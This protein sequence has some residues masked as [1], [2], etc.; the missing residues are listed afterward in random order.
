MDRSKTFRPPRRARREDMEPKDLGLPVSPDR[1]RQ[2]TV[3]GI[4]RGN[5]STPASTLFSSTPGKTIDREAP[6]ALHYHRAQFFYLVAWFL[7]AERA[8]RKAGK[9]PKPSSRDEVGSFNLVAG[10]LNQEMFITLAGPSTSLTTRRT[11]RN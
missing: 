1:E 6:H 10:V 8:R 2:R 3:A 9:T 7:E 4:R 5:S 11:G